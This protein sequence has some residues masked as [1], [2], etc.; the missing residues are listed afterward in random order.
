MK[1]WANKKRGLKLYSKGKDLYNNEFYIQDSSWAC[2]RGVR[3]YAQDHT[4][5]ID[6][7]EICIDLTEKGAKQV[8]KG[9]EEFLKDN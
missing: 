3:I 4:L 1:K 8:I 9:L 2:V 5:N 7:V 6:D